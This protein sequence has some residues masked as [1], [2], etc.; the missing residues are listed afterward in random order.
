MRPRALTVLV[1]LLAAPL[2][3]AHTAQPSAMK[4]EATSLLGKPLY[5]IQL[6]PEAKKTAEANLLKAREDYAKAPESADAII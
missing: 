4:P 3:A 2:A 1:L 6:A 5:P